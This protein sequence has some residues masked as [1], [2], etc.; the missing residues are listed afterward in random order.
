MAGLLPHPPSEASLKNLRSSAFATFAAFAAFAALFPAASAQGGFISGTISGQVTSDGGAVPGII[1]GS[2]V[3]GS[4]IYDDSTTVGSI[5]GPVNPFTAFSLTIGTNPYVFSLTDLQ[6]GGELTPGKVPGISTPIGD[7][8]CF[9]FNYSVISS[10][11]G[12]TVVQQS[13]ADKPPQSFS[14]GSSDLA[15]SFTFTFNGMSLAAVPEPSSFTLLG[16]SCV[17][18]SG[19]GRRL[20]GRFPAC[21]VGR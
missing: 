8:L 3:T 11:V 13:I 19:C 21:W 20:R 14:V 15:H 10:Y 17:A 12:A 7:A 1:T 6:T 16:V 9:F 5:V 18:L 4:Y 2:A